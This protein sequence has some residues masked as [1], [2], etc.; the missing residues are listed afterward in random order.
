[1]SD[2]TRNLLF[3]LLIIVI[4]QMETYKSTSR[5]VQADVSKRNGGHSDKYR[6]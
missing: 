4:L 1:M 6:H 5:D 3:E 2:M